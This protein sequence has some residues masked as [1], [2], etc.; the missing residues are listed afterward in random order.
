MDKKQHERCESNQRHPSEK[1]D[2]SLPCPF[3][4][5]TNAVLSSAAQHWPPLASEA[6]ALSLPFPPPP[7][8]VGQ[9]PGNARFLGTARVSVDF[10]QRL[11]LALT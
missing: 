9:E 8:L 11:S 10:L 7:P 6:F 3:Y 5:H 2:S 4:S 1:L